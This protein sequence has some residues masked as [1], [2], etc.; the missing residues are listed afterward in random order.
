IS[1][2][3]RGTQSEILR[4]DLARDSRKGELEDSRKHSQILKSSNARSLFAEVGHECEVHEV[5]AL[6]VRFRVLFVKRVHLVGRKRFGEDVRNGVVRTLDRRIDDEYIKRVAAS[7]GWGGV[8]Y[9]PP[10]SLLFP[11]GFFALL[12][13]FF[14]LRNDCLEVRGL[15][16][17][18]KVEDHPGI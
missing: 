5:L 18:N 2:T 9:I 7:G 13:G 12:E 15:V 16:G 3:V 4:A 14:Q 8:G 6:R 17:L 1:P 11:L 10:G